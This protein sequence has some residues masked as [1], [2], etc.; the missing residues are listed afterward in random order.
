MPTYEITAPDGSVY[1]IEAPDGASEADA[2]SFLQK[3]LTQKPKPDPHKNLSLDDIRNKYRSAQKAGAGEADLAGLADAYVAKE[4]ERAR[5]DADYFGQSVVNAIGNVMR[6]V[7]RGVGVPVLG[8]AADEANAYLSSLTGGDYQE[9]LDYQRARDRFNDK[10]YGTL[11][12]VTQ[13]A[14]GVAGGGALM[15]SMG[16]FG[17]GAAV[18]TGRRVLSGAGTGAGI[19]A[20]DMFSRGEGGVTDRALNATV[21]AGLGGVFGG[22]APL[23]GT[24]VGAG[25]EKLRNFLSSDAALRKL[26]ISRGAAETLIR[27]LQTDDT[28]SGAG[29]QRIRESGPDAMLADAGEAS[30]GLLDT[31]LQRSGPGATAAR[32]AI[33]ERAQLANRQLAQKL[34]NTFGG[35]AAGVRT[36]QAGIRRG[37]AAARSTAYDD[38]YNAA[39]DYSTPE[40]QQVAALW[41]RVR[42][43]RRADANALLQEAGEPIIE[44]GAMPT[45][46]QIDYVTRALNN[47]AES[48]EGQGALGGVNT[49]GRSAQELS[50][51]LRRATRDAVPEYG[52]AL[53][54]AAD[55]ISRVQA[56]NFGSKLLNQATRREDVVE[57]L[58]NASVAERRAMAEGVRDQLD[59]IVAN[60]KGLV[61]DPNTEARQLKT[62]VQALSTD[63]VRQKVTA[64]IG[65]D[66]ARAFF[67]QIGRF[68]RAAELRA[69]VARGSQTYGRMTTDAQVKAM[70]EPGII[71]LTLSG[72]PVAAARKFVQGLTGMTPE[73]RLAAEDKLFGEIADALTRVRGT[74]AETM[75][76][77]LRAAVQARANNQNVGSVV[78]RGVTA[79]TFNAA[80]SGAQQAINQ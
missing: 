20:A 16:L 28:F 41:S 61:S 78:R 26:G 57:A 27:R 29:A 53:D 74:Q 48:N 71:G 39:I 14:G 22:V 46:R 40:G 75:L 77:R 24:A 67:G 3:Q 19:G 69:S 66:Q 50:R 51:A 9:A 7:A 5:G 73:R 18:P 6:D 21:G 60:V 17:G 2:I 12:T 55:P 43:S 8:G 10:H 76:N 45:V 35:P 25:A 32:R 34:D 49:V 15:R 47:V 1:E 44:D 23:V 36:R 37:T 42:P 58:R 59:E 38:A 4:Q 62:A 33:E 65:Q 72:N 30:T 70:T 63:A 13:L 31:A 68:S 79:S 54:T 56:I 64:L 11:S 80:Q 52:V